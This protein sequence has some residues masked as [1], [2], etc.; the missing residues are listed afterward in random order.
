M[1]NSFSI[2]FIMGLFSLLLHRTI[3]LKPF[4]LIS[5]ILAFFSTLNND[6]IL[7]IG[8]SSNTQIQLFSI[9]LLIVI[10]AFILHE[11]EDITMTQTLFITASSILLLQSE[12][13]VSFIL[14]FEA[15]SIISVAFIS[16]I[17][18]KQQA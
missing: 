2:L 16:Y 13:V 15:L 9:V 4:A 5:V 11:D 10:F 3:F 7:L 1:I 12:T 14:S 18:T 17:Q 8:F 6:A